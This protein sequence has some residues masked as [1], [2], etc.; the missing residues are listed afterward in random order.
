MEVR[1]YMISQQDKIEIEALKQRIPLLLANEGWEAY[2]SNFSA[3]YQNWHMLSD[4]VR[5]RD[6][7]LPLV[8][9][10][11]EEGNR[12]IGSEVETV[13][14]IP[15][16]ENKVMYLHKQKEAFSMVGRNDTIFRDIRFISVFIKELGVW[17]VEFTAFMDAP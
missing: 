2:E 13:A 6:D 3:D 15:L 10:W 16:T 14:F 8:K 5:D 12:A 7:F 11:Y 17:K 9:Q 1:G 4:E